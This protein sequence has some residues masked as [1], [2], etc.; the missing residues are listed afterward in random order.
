MTGGHE[1]RAPLI[2]GWREHIALPELGIR[3]MHAKVDTGA[4]TSALHATRIG[5]I[6]RDGMP[7]VRFHI[8]HSHGLRARDCEAPLIT[9]RSVRNTSGIPEERYVIRTLLRLGR[10]RWHIEVSLADRG[11]MV[12]P[13]IIGRTAIR[14]HRILVD[15]GKSFLIAPTAGSSRANSKERNK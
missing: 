5:E 3:E 10:R 15:P 2:I 13:I 11:M 8:P 9:R 7:W 12:M 1:P 14:R 6:E 4:R